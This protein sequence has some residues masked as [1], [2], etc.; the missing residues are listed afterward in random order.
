MDRRKDGHV[1][2]EAEIGAMY[3]KSPGEEGDVTT[4]VEIGVM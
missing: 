2:T 1:K 3:P 4:G